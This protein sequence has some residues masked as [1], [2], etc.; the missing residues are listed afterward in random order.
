MDRGVDIDGASEAVKRA[1][2]RERE[3]AQCTNQQPTK[4]VN[5]YIY[6]HIYMYV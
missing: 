3:A 6:M 4:P 5:T 1:A 2:A